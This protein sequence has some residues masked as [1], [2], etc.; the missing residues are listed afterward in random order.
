M[1]NHAFKG[2]FLSVAL[3]CL[4]LLQYGCETLDAHQAPISNYD[5][6]VINRVY[7]RLNNDPVT[8]MINFSVSSENGTVTLSG[9]VDNPQ[10]RMRA[11]NIT[12]ST[13]GVQIVI[14]RMTR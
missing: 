14:D 12:Q 13:T 4:G 8:R 5:K 10:V 9:W 6:E 11:I 7:Q 2:L 3:S 1:K